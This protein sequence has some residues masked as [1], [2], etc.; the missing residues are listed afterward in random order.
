F[1]LDEYWTDESPFVQG[2]GVEF[3]CFPLGSTINSVAGRT[4]DRRFFYFSSVVIEP[5]EGWTTLRA[6]LQLKSQLTV[7]D[8]YMLLT[9]GFHVISFSRC[10]MKRHD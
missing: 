1:S 5:R 7:T 2:G 10:T 8:R 3:D 9:R 6:L 4:I